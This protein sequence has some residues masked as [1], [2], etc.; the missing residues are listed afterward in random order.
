MKPPVVAVYPQR[1]RRVYTDAL[2]ESAEKTRA[3]ALQA[4][5]LRQAISA[6]IV[7]RRRLD[8]SGR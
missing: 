2:A 8:R 3:M 7:A 1:N 5:N 6:A 4:R